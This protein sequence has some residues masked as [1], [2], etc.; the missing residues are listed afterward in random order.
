[1]K[2]RVLCLLFA[3]TL[4]LSALFIS[5]SEE[6]V[7][8]VP[9]AFD[10]TAVAGTP[11]VPDGMGYGEIDAK[12]VYLF[13]VCGMVKVV[14]G[15]ADV[16]FTSPDSNTVWL[17]LRIQS[18]SGT[19]LGET[20]LIKPGEYVQSATFTTTPAAG[21]KIVLRVMSYQPDTYYS[22]GEVKLNTTAS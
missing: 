7:P 13:S 21:D 3:L 10:A 4:G 5:C 17:K 8:F 18:E 9:P 14:D 16:W 22:A 12:G 19:I 15:K 2:K 1:M 11:T 20:G 6:P